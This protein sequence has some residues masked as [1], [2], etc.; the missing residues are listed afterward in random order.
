MKMEVESPTEL[1]L[2]VAL[3]MISR[4]RS[5]QDQRCLRARVRSRTNYVV[6]VV[7]VVVVVVIFF[8]ASLV[9]LIDALH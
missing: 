2:A 7:D 6:V 4:L 8:K 3:S 5:S 1:F 9:Q